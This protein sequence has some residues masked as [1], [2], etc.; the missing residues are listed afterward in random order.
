VTVLGIEG[1]I[2]ANNPGFDVLL[3][4]H[5]GSVLASLGIVVVSGV[6]AGR[7]LA[8][9]PS[10]RAPASL[11]G[12]YAPGLNWAGRVLYLVPVFGFALVGTS[13]GV[14][15]LGDAW[16][17]SGISLWLV[18][19]GLAEWRLW[20]AERRIQRLLVP[21]EA[22]LDRAGPGGGRLA[23]ELS[24]EVTTEV[25]ACGRSVVAASILVTVSLLTAVVLMVA[26]PG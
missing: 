16:L 22:V 14:A 25:R 15:E 11:L 17:L 24:A 19:A 12:Y 26:R 1:V 2:R 4:C 6:Q 13:G 23:T 3:L 5:I 10:D 8:L 18:S 7:L 21:D 20:P 9:G